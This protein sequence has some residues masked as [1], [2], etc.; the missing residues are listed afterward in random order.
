MKFYSL[1]WKLWHW[2]VDK[3]IALAMRNP[4]THLYHGDGTLYMER[5]WLVPYP[6]VK[7]ERDIGC[8]RMKWWREPFGWLCQQF[9]IAIRIHHICTADFDR[10]LHDHPW[11]FVS[12][13][14]RGGYIE[15]RPLDN[16]HPCF[17]HGSEEVASNTYRREASMV[18]RRAT[19]RHRIINVGNCWTL[20]IT[21]PKRQW[22]GFY[23]PSGK[24]Y[25]KDFDSVHDAINVGR[26]QA[27]AETDHRT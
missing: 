17:G 4:F 25:Y 3:L 6:D 14:L 11:D 7:D 2:T 18:Y 24:V 10:A 21:G 27:H 12:V 15:R 16:G 23:I 22:W 26:P 8:Y 1:R 20:F 9:E 19:D 5:Y 13:V